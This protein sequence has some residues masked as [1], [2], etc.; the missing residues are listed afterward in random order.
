MGTCVWFSAER[1]LKSRGILFE[2]FTQK[3]G[4]AIYAGYG[5]Y[6]WVFN[7]VSDNVPPLTLQNGG[8]HMAWN[9]VWLSSSLLDLLERPTPLVRVPKEM[10]VYCAAKHYINDLPMTITQANLEKVLKRFPEV[11]AEIAETEVR[12]DVQRRL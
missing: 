1:E 8:S 11:Q 9:H 2:K 7:P 5:S 10:L 12:L 4:D 3:P 6:H